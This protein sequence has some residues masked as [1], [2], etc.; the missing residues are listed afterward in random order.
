MAFVCVTMEGWTE[1]MYWV[2]DAYTEVTFVYFF[3][4]I[5]IG[6][7]FLLNLTLAVIKA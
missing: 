3:A 2:F 6:S 1:I 5:W 7:F 4:M